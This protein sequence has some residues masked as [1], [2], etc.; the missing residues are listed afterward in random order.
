MNRASTL[1]A[2]VAPTYEINDKLTLRAPLYFGATSG[3]FDVD[4]NT[5]DGRFAVNAVT[6]MADFSPWGNVIRLSGGIGIGGY[7]LDGTATDLTLDG[8]TYAGLSTV[9]VSQ[10]E[11]LA[12]ILSVGFHREFANGMTVFGDI[13]GRIA[14]Y[15]VSVVTSAA[16]SPAEQADLDASVADYNSDLAEIGVTPFVA[17][18]LGFRF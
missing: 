16:L 2:F 13:G 8:N 4:G 3:D 15:Q 1:G 10:N 11:D 7:D 6:L 9:S 17:L 12:P 14:T 18:G 5:V